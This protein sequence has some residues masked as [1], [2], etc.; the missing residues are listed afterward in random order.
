MKKTMFKKSISLIMTVL[1]VMSCWVFF[2]G[3]IPEVE[4][5]STEIKVTTSFTLSPNGNRGNDGSWTRLALTGE[6][7]AGGT[8]VVLFRFTNADLKNLADKDEINLQF[9]AYSCNNRLS[10]N[11]VGVTVNAD[12]YYITKNSSFVS[13][14]GTNKSTNVADT[15]NSVLGTDYTYSYAQDKAKS[16]FGLSDNTLVGSFEQPTIN[17]QDNASLRTGDANYSYPVTEIV[18]QKAASDEDLS[19]IVMLRQGYSCSGDRGWSDIYI[20]SSTIS[21][22]GYNMLEELKSKIEAYEGYFT[23]GIFY[24]NLLNNYKAYNDAKRYYDA[25]TYGGVQFDAAMAQSY[26][27][28]IDTAIAQTGLNDTYVDYLNAEVKSQN[29]TAIGADYRKNVIW[30]PWDFSW[31]ITSDSAKYEVQDT[32]FYWTMPN[33][34]VGITNDSETTFPLHTFF[35]TDTGSRW[36]RYII[37]GSSVNNN[38]ANNSVAGTNDFSVAGNWRVS[39]Y[40]NGHTVSSWASGD[41]GWGDWIYES[42]YDSSKSLDS[43]EDNN[44]NLAYS[45][46]WIYQVSNYATINKTAVGVNASNTYGK[47]DTGFTFGTAKSANGGSTGFTSRYASTSG[48]NGY[49][50]VV[51]MDTYKNNYQNWKTL[52]P[53][54]SYKDYNGFVYSDATNVTTR[55]DDASGLL[56][57]LNLTEAQ[58]ATNIDS[59]VTIWA[60]NVNRGAN[61]LA[62]AKAA[63][64]TRVTTK[65]VDLIDA[66]SNSKATYAGGNTKYTYASWNNFVAAYNAAKEH[67]ASLNPDGSNVQYSSNATEIGNLAT[68]LNNAKAALKERTYDVTY[69]NMFSFSSWANSASGFIGTPAKGTMTYDVN[70]GTITFAN[71]ANNTQSNP[72]DHYTSYGF[73]NDH[74]NMTLVP[75]ETYT[76]EYTTSGG[77]GD[78]VHIFFYDDNGNAVA[79]KANGGSPFA[80]AYGTGR[81]THTISFTAPENATKAAFRFGSTVLGDSITFSNIYMYSHTRGDYADIANWTDRP[82]R[83]VFNYGQALGTTLEVPTRP[84]HTFDGWWVDSI[85]PNGQKDEGE[86]V[87][88][89]SGTVVTNLQNF[90]IAQDWI[91]YSEWTVNKYTV[92]FETAYG[93]TT[94]AQYDYGTPADSI[95]KPANTAADYDENNHYAYSWPAISDV[96]GDVTYT[97]VKTPTAHSYSESI[98]TAPTCTT[99]GLK[100]YTCNCGYSY[101]AAIDKAAHTPGAAA[102]CTAPQTCTVCGAE[103][104]AKLGHTEVDIPAVPATCTVPG[105]T[106]GKKCSVCSV[107]LVAQTDTALADHTEA[108]REEDRV[109]ATCGKDGSYKLVTYCSV[110]STVIKTE[111]KTIAATGNHTWN[112]GEIT[113]EP[114]CQTEGTKTYTCTAENCGATYTETVAK[115]A[116]NYTNPVITRPTQNTDGT[117]TDGKYTYTCS[118]GCNGSIEEVAKRADYTELE[119]AVSELQTLNNNEKLNA[120]AKAEIAQALAKANALADD[121]VTSEQP[122]ID[123]LVKELLKAKAHVEEILE[124]VGKPQPITE[125]VSG[126]KVQFLKKTGVEAI[127]SVQLNANGGFDTARLKLTNN[128]KDLP[129]TVVGITSNKTATY[130]DTSDTPSANSVSGIVIDVDKDKDLY[131]GAPASF[132]E[133]GL[134]TYTITYK[135]GSDATGYLMDKD[136][137]AVEFETKAYIYVKGAAFTPYHFMDERAAWPLTATSKW[138]HY[139]EAVNYGD[140]ELVSYNTASKFSDKLEVGTSN[141][142]FRHD[143]YDYC[144]DG[145]QAGCK[146]NDYATGDAHAA[147]YKF[148]VDTSLAPTWEAA[149]FRVRITETA[150]SVYE[151]APLK[152][153]RLAVNQAYLD[154]ISGSD[155]TFKTTFVPSPSSNV[156]NKTWIVTSSGTLDVSVYENPDRSEYLF[157][158]HKN[159]T[160]F[161]E[162]SAYVNFSGSIPVDVTE[163][164]FMFSPRIEFNGKSSSES[165]TMTSHIW[166]TSY[167]KGALRAAVNAAEQAAYNPNYYDSDKY[168]AYQNALMAAKEVLGKAETTQDEVDEKLAALN[169]AVTELVKAE[170]RAEYVLTVTHSIRENADMTAEPANKISY[171]LLEKGSTFTVPYDAIKEEASKINKYDDEATLTITDTAKHTYNYWYINYSKVQDALD[172]AEEILND[173]T[174]GYSDEYIA[175]VKEA[176]EALEKILEGQDATTTP[177]SQKTVDDAVK[178]VTDLTGHECNEDVKIS[179]YAATCIAEGLTDGTKCSVC[180]V[181]MTAQTTIPA[182]GHTFG[183]TTTANAATCLAAGNK[184]YKQCT[185]CNLYFAENAE[186]NAVDGKE[187]TTSFVINKLDH[188]Y[189]GEY[190][191]HNYTDKP[192]AHSQKCV[193]GCNKYGNETECTFDEDVTAPTCSANGYTTYTCT[194]C[195]NSYQTDYTTRDHVYVY[196]PG[197][198]TSHTVTCKYNDCDYTATENCSGGTATCT[199][200]ATCEKCNTAWG[201]ELGHHWSAAEYTWSKAESW[202]CVAVRECGRADCDAKE[203]ATATITSAEKTAATC[204]EDG[205]TTY[206][207]IFAEEWTTTQYKDVQDIPALT[208]DWSDWSFDADGKHKRVCGNDANHVETESCADSATDSDCNCDKCGNL[209]AHSYGDASCDAPATC[210]V[211]GETTGSALGHDYTVFVETVDYTCTAGGYDVYKCSRCDATEHKNL[212]AAAHRPEADY[213]VIAKATCE[214]DGYKAILCSKCKEELETETIAKREHVYK[215]NGVKTPATCL[216][217]GVMNTICTNEETDTHAACTHEST[218]V[219]D[220]LGHDK[221]THEAKTPTCTEIGWDAYET[222]KREGCDYTTYVEK[223]ALGHEFTKETATEDYL[224]T[225]ATC[226]D[227]AVYY[228]SCSRC[229]LSSKGQTGEAIFGSGTELGHD[230][231]LTKGTSN[232]NGNHTV[233][234]TRCEEG[235][236]GHTNIVDCTYGAGVVTAPTCTKGGYTTHTCT[237]CSYSYEDTV[238]VAT[239]HSFG[240][241]K[242]NN[243]G[244]HT[245]ECTVCS[246]EEGRVESGACTYGEWTETKAPTCLDDGEKAH[247]CSVCKNTVT[248]VI[249][250]NGH[251]FG[252]TTAAKE[253]TCIAAGNEAYK[254][255]TACNKFFA[256]DAANDSADGKADATSFVI[257]IDPAKHTHLTKTDAVEN[258]CETDGNIDYWICDGCNNI[259]KDAAATQKITKDETIVAA[260]GHDYDKSETEANLTRPVKNSDGTWEKGYYTFI[261]KNDSSHKDYKFVERADYNNYEAAR[262]NLEGLLN[263][264]LTDEAKEAIREVLEENKIAD[265]LIA[266]EQDAVNTAEDN[267]KDCFEQY[268]GSLKTYTVIFVVDGKQTKTTVVSGN[269][270]VAPTD[271]N[272]DRDDTYHY[273]FTGWDNEFTNITSDLT[274]TAKFDAVEHVYT[275]HTDKDD[276]YHTDKCDCGYSK[277][278]KHTETSEVTTKAT[279]EADGVKTYTC[280]VCQGTRTEAIAKRDHVYEDNGVKTPATCLADGV[281]NT[282]CTNE[283]TD[284]HA[285]CTHESTRAIIQLSHSYTGEIKSDGNGKDATHS[286]KCVNGCNEYGAAVKH[287][288]NGGEVTTPAT[289]L[290][291]GV[292]TYTCT[293]SGCGATYTEDVNAN[294]HTFGTPV[295]ANAATCIATGN[296][297]YKQC[298]VCNLYFAE[299]AATNAADGKEDTTSFVINKLDHSYTGEYQWNDSATPKT[300]SQKCVN[301]CNEYGNET[302]CTFGEVVTAPTCSA[303]GYTTYTCTVCNNSYQADYTTRDHVYVYAP[304]N[305]TS[306]TVTCKYNDCDYTA[307]ENCSGGTATCTT[308]ATC[309]KCNTAWGEELG[310]HWSAAEYTW[311]KAESWSCVAVRECGRADCDAKETAT[312]TITSAEKTAATCTED[313]W[314]T[315]TAIFAEEW[316]TTQYKDVQDIPALTHDWSDWSF[317][318]DGKHKRVCANDTNH[319]ETEPCADSANDSDCNCDKC[320]NLVAHSYGDASCDAPA[321]CTECG[322]TT[323]DKLGHSFTNYVSD[324]NATCA[325]DGTKTA[326]CDRCDKT[327][328]VTD[329]GSALDHA[330]GDWEYVDGTGTHQRVCANDPSHVETANCSGDIEYTGASC[331]KTGIRI[332]SCNVCG[333]KETIEYPALGHEFIDDEN[334]TVVIEATCTQVGSVNLKCVRCDELKYMGIVPAKGHRF[335]KV[336]EAIAPTCTTPGRSDVERCLSCN[337]EEPAEIYPATG[338]SIKDGKCVT[339]GAKEY[340]GD[341]YCSCICHND[342]MFMRFIYMIVRFFWRIFRMNKS[343]DCSAVHY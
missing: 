23:N 336:T 258:T 64:T 84:G 175:N 103:L 252:G 253:E 155:K 138:Q 52:I 171:Y 12:I 15:G 25:V 242:T 105:K 65:Y 51:Y 56:L 241:W 34:I 297:A 166:L 67:M 79:N 97:E 109:E 185:V 163:A 176:E 94:S 90:G 150:E 169:T 340:E 206:T 238:T 230:Y 246:D 277:D 291:K 278:V 228:K 233:T 244:T 26:I 209:V 286:Y 118:N 7:A 285:A 308:K 247:T 300:H 154:G 193:N 179:G 38:T 271:T 1:M 139:F 99:E 8:S 294:G 146:N 255:C 262:N 135:I 328:T 130:L 73:G 153:V 183:D 165:V 194:V 267:L 158:E 317:D 111:A 289:C 114:T 232:N 243:D 223:P 10:H 318:A 85:N 211:C 251:T 313:G 237:I 5:A 37:A 225:A 210:T 338:H 93:T 50:Y 309:E 324:G 322:E 61:S 47:I 188:S 17:G 152:Y 326:K 127:D 110:C 296:K 145:C 35:W 323:G 342:S 214:K 224:K 287:T 142:G 276:T 167:D 45:Q 137:N 14:Q 75:G 18:K 315:Y 60:T 162:T 260:K 204:T 151:N 13:G 235:T 88:D 95:V 207:A 143:A 43:F 229:D 33:I 298:T 42:G 290:D 178:A 144:E 184:A 129:I 301:G 187:D 116:H 274:V 55:L 63:G 19:F 141:F 104:V 177:T 31:D 80:H 119:A 312:A 157:G 314:T 196:A 215:D 205:W 170:N 102:T 101:T 36:L 71:D 202:S 263:T 283:E 156:P 4:A 198:G 280:S 199:T 222:C 20:D 76:F 273:V 46:P 248:E 330:Y 334:Y 284:T 54:I 299:N 16:Y 44:N 200:K 331:T 83:T 341:Q 77:T 245:R 91:L 72:N 22:S 321:T 113:V 70:A 66:I 21:L 100:T 195:N 87:T 192:K 281:M 92:T 186:T 41:Q 69:E 302:V 293:V 126:L 29:G 212:T 98:T 3:M 159:K 189:T 269:S 197:N 57:N 173:T 217:D 203:T 6:S 327:D 239:G 292:K 250:A 108:T 339:C 136:G 216:T 125:A 180:G 131:I 160:S 257:A 161:D 9:Y 236:E 329:I 62:S 48:R 181:I 24:T 49:I 288:W 147:T 2:P 11:N 332:I 343:C 220:K 128:N 120:D 213:T 306:H 168:E 295:V 310:H 219:L 320:G 333:G 58:R 182:S 268:K 40:N 122:Q 240:S 305:G 319:V 270:A 254:Q 148:Y 59:T 201:E 27:N 316:T 303:E 272:K 28:T 275:T 86:Q 282:I 74:Y 53:A 81:G 325:K 132:K 311:S 231:D 234:C 134:I 140:F 265:N 124:N 174:S 96:T 121:L 68:A 218:R 32:R 164:K 208:H 89:D 82:N 227:A 256:A 149:G 259:Y 266:S 191:W 39:S 264:D 107:I 249:P 221:V 115:L 337:Y 117:W 261:C 279:C 335:F 106:A 304:G 30:Y 172:A 123:E 190:Q 226:N 307:T 112:D 133:A 78:Q